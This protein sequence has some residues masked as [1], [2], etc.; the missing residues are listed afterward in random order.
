[1]NAEEHPQLAGSRLD[2]VSNFL[3]LQIVDDSGMFLYR[4]EV[5]PEVDD[6]RRKGFLVRR[7]FPGR[8]KHFDDGAMVF[9]PQRY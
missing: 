6:K 9:F 1:M 5:K 7:A 4:V 2:A 3:R 8:V